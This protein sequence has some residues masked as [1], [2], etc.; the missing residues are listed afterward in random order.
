MST[1]RECAKSCWGPE[2][3][4]RGADLD[5][6]SVHSLSV[7]L[8]VLSSIHSSVHSFIHFGLFTNNPSSYSVTDNKAASTEDAKIDEQ[9]L[10][11]AL[12][13]EKDSW[14]HDVSRVHES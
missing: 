11:P 3:P 14:V 13:S 5:P 1:F 2:N 12:G 9:G 10:V 8:A 6:S 7:A 4:E